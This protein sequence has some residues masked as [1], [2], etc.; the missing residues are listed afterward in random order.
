MEFCQ[1]KIISTGGEGGMVSTNNEEYF[2]K[3]WSLKDH[4]KSM[5]AIKNMNNGPGF[6]WLHESFGSNYR[7]T[8][9]QSAMGRYQLKMLPAWRE[10]RKRMP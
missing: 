4:G 2:E 9:L 5:Q 1:D 3:M 10:I 8:E 6:K 7:L